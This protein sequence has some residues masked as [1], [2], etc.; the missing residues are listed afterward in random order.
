MTDTKPFSPTASLDGDHDAMLASL[1]HSAPVRLMATMNDVVVA[2]ATEP[3]ADAMR[4]ADDQRFDFLPVRE[5]ADGPIIGLFRRTDATETG[6]ACV[7]RIM[8]PLSGDI[9]IGADAPLLD[10]VYAADTHPCR[11]VLGRRGIEGL[12]TLSDIQR[13]PVRTVLF[14]LFIH[15]ELLLTDALRRDLG[16]DQPP[17][18]LLSPDRAAKTRERWEAAKNADMDR[19]QFNALQFGDKKSIAKKRRLLGISASRINEDLER[20]ERDLRNPIA[21]GVDFAIT[22]ETALKVVRASRLVRDWIQRLRSRQGR[23]NE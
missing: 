23:Q 21:H 3:V 6:S 17:F 12:V 8:Q 5:N 1:E 20:I 22:E 18:D 7:S 13:L 11:L 15:L 2:L 9:L 19:D 14:S 10:F 4:R 16:P